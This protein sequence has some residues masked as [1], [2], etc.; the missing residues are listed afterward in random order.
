MISIGAQ[1][2]RVGLA[3]AVVGILTSPAYAYLDPGTGSMLL[4]VLLGGVAGVALAGRLYWHRLLA[5]F[6]LRKSADDP[7]VGNTGRERTPG[8]PSQR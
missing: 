7:V 5:L 8:A 3:A 2:F 4:Q 6:G 1:G